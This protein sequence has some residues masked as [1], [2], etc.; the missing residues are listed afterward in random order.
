MILRLCSSLELRVPNQYKAYSG[1]LVVTVVGMEPDSNQATVQ[2]LER[3]EEDKSRYSVISSI[4]VV[5]PS[6]SNVSSSVT[7]K[8]PCGI[9]TRGGRYGVR[10]EREFDDSHSTF[11]DDMV[12]LEVSWPAARLALEP[13]IIQTYPE[14]PVTATVQFEEAACHQ[15]IGTLLPETWLQLLYCGHSP[16]TCNNNSSHKQ[17]VYSEQ[18]RGFPRLRVISLRCDL[19]G[20]AGHYALALQPHIAALGLPLATSPLHHTLK[21]EWSEKFVFNVHANSIFPCDGHVP[22]LFQYPECILPT[23]DRVR[24][25]GRLRADVSALLPPTT[26]HYLAE[27]RINRGQHALKF[28]CDLF[29]EKFVEYCFVYVSQAITGAVSDV[30]MDC[31]P[32]LPVLESETG[33]WGAWSPWTPCTTTCS[34][35]TRNR[36]RFCDSPPPRYGAKFCQGHTFETER[37]GVA[38]AWDCIF[39]QDSG[40]PEV[41]ADRPEVI[42]EVGPGCRCGCVVHLGMTKPRRLI[43]S[44]SQ[45]CPGRTFWL[46]QADRT[47]MV[48]L[49]LEQFRLPCASQWLKVRDG[50]SMSSN[51]LAQLGGMPSLPYHISSSGPWLLLEFHSDVKVA[52]GQECWGGFLAHAQQLDPNVSVIHGRVMPVVST[53]PSALSRF[54]LV[55]VAVLIILSVV[56][57]VSA[58]MGA[59]YIHRYRKYQLAAATE[60]LET[61]TDFSSG[62]R[63][64]LAPLKSRAASSSTLL[65][66]VI[67]LRRFHRGHNSHKHSRLNEEDHDNDDD[68]QDSLDSHKEDGKEGELQCE[69]N[70]EIKENI[71]MSVIN[72]SKEEGRPTSLDVAI[73]TNK[74]KGGDQTP[75][76]HKKHRKFKSPVSP[77]DEGPEDSEDGGNASIKSYDHRPP[78]SYSSKRRNSNGVKPSISSSVSSS[79]TNAT[80]SPVSSIRGI[81]PKESKEKRNLAKLLA[82][83]E[84]SLGPDTDLELDYY[85]YNVQNASTVPGS[86][87]GMDPAYCVWIPPFAPGQWNDDDDDDDEEDDDTEGGDINNEN[88]SEEEIDNGL[89]SNEVSAGVELTELER[90]HDVIT[91]DEKNMTLKFINSK[92]S[93]KTTGFLDN[94]NI[95]GSRTPV[96][97]RSD[98]DEK[99]GSTKS[100]QDCYSLN[101]F[102]QST[103]LSII[104]EKNNSSE[105]TNC[106]KDNLTYKMVDKLVPHS[107]VKVHQAYRVREKETRVEKSPS[108]DS[109]YYDLLDNDESDIKFADEDEEEN[110]IFDKKESK[111]DLTLIKSDDINKRTTLK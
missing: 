85:D 97:D 73:Q 65:S 68:Y 81:N 21:A 44:S 77:V 96:N 63:G 17:V 71:Q 70:D 109:E 4:S 7:V 34:G 89:L 62:S 66:E 32:T 11:G 5:P 88:E 100:F 57:L 72:D 8:F 56:F 69:K 19:F 94:D 76:V 110:E 111:N 6:S 36:Y 78:S 37:C 92:Y 91:D 103:D 16:H 46:I 79:L 23:G 58:C 31:V 14:S 67:S 26:L 105:Q 33:G 10:L 24:V 75:S 41:P 108:N 86:Y 39:Y 43:A 104:S 18:I 22:V 90:D 102:S 101:R 50:D 20:L 53:A 95:S 38:V 99:Y 60:D 84:F 3:Y 15:E 106:L 74:L 83:S 51:L 45:S 40:G 54:A 42:A 47:H 13:P 25:F 30:R 64:S 107:P 93:D 35:G 87:I 28:D 98:T 61:I 55:H 9:I 29:T 59:Q 82:G 1:D 80:S 2:L 12:E 52:A 48:R 49:S 27:Q